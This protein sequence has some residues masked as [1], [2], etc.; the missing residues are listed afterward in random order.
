MITISD[1]QKTCGISLGAIL[2]IA[3][4]AG[5]FNNPLLGLFEMSIIQKIIYIVLGLIGILLSLRDIGKQYN[6]WL[7][8][9]MA[10]FAVLGFV[11]P[12]ASLLNAVLNINLQTTILH[13]G[14]AVLSLIVGFGVNQESA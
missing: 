6:K 14:I 3:G 10:I 1:L 7:G 9:F 12:T 5:F 11:P 2:I 4:T 8:I 13:T